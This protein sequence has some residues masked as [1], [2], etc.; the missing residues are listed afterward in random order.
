M[1]IPLQF[2]FRNKER[3]ASAFIDN[4]EE[5]CFVFLIL[6]DKEIIKEFGEDISIKTD[7]ENILPS[8]NASVE[9]EKLREAIFHELRRTVE[10]AKA[11]EEYP[12][13]Q[14]WPSQKQII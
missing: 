6:E 3:K 9:L 5:P 14:Q 12:K 13:G 1:K 4:Q 8:D 2:R 7:F 11:K 10:F